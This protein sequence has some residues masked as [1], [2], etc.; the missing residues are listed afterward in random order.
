M[1]A[2][3]FRG[4]PMSCVERIDAMFWEYLAGALVLG[5][6]LGSLLG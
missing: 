6:A 5:T 1:T 2:S 3:L 4:K